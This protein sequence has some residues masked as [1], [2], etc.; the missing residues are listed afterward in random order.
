MKDILDCTHNE[1]FRERGNGLDV[2]SSTID[3]KRSDGVSPV[4]QKDKGYEIDEDW[5]IEASDPI[6]V[7]G[8]ASPILEGSW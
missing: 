5:G 4:S 6:A 1:E 8:S 3:G 7:E 2:G